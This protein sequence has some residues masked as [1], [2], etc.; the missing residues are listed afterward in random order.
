MARQPPRTRL[1]LVVPD[2]MADYP[3]PALGGRTPLEAARRPWMDRV[4]ATGVLLRV[5][6]TPAGMDPGSDITHLSLLGVDPRA[7]YTG[8][9]PLEALGQGLVLKPSQT[10]VRMNLVSLGQA[11]GREVL[12]DFSAGHISS[13]EARGLVL[14]LADKLRGPG[15]SF[16]PGVGYRHLL[17]V[18]GLDPAGLRTVPP[19]DIMGRPAAD[20]YPRGPGARRLAE[21]MERSREV[22]RAAP[23]NEARRR[24]GKPAADMI[25]LWGAGRA[26]ALPSFRDL[27]GLRGAA[28]TAVDLIRG[29]ARA[30]GLAVLEV[31]GATGY[32][33]TD[34]AAKGRRAAQALAKSDFVLVHVEAPDEA[35]HNGDAARKVEAIERVD[36]HVV[37]PVYRALEKVPG[38]RLAVLPDHYTPVSVRTHAPE[39]VPGAATAFGPARP[40]APPLTEKAAAESGLLVDPGRLLLARIIGRPGG[41]PF[42]FAEGRQP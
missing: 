21:L 5:R 38:A 2:G 16:H 8:R 42:F 6:T 3:V 39:P 36:E 33:D 19:H 32:Y 24:A 4:A 9:A 40:R 11:E 37:G 29:I 13:P 7:G 27:F 12:A 23:E 28:I 18:E 31:P 26:P 22:L 15:L 30:L 41:E 34:Y 14:R 17:L 35:G 20:H 25:W 10:A 1:C